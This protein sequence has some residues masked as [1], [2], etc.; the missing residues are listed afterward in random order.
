[1]T[2]MMIRPRRAT[3][4]VRVLIHRTHVPVPPLVIFP[5]PRLHTGRFI[6]SGF[7][8]PFQFQ[9]VHLSSVFGIKS[10]PPKPL[11]TCSPSDVVNKYRIR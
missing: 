9:H 5:I 11:H 2:R 6:I 3:K 10:Q 4:A 8:F 1:M 7:E